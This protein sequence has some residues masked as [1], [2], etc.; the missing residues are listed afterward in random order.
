[1]WRWPGPFPIFIDPCVIDPTLPF[2]RC[3]GD[4]T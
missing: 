2:C 4:E 1:L 3:P